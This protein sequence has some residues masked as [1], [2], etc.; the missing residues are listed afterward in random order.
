[1]NIKYRLIVLAA[2]LST[3]ILLAATAQA[4]GYHP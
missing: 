1:M 4:G 2:T 3:P